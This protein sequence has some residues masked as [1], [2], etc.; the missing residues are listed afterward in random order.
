ME[1]GDM[2]SEKNGE[3]ILCLLMFG[4]RGEKR[5]EKIHDMYNDYNAF[6]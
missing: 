5:G 4:Q 6:I 1:G 2:E 3:I